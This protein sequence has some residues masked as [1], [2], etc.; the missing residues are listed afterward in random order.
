[1]TEADSQASG[2][3]LE[4]AV[5]A[6]VEAVEV[7]S[8][9]LGRAAPGGTSVEPAFELVDD[10]L[11]VRLE[12]VVLAHSTPYYERARRFLIEDVRR[13]RDDDFERL[14]AAEAQGL[15]GFLA[16]RTGDRALAEMVAAG[17]EILEE[18]QR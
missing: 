17:V 13:M 4:L 8:E 5:E 7:V 14:Y 1:M 15:F 18:E 6:D 3:W 9:I 16:Y 10:G 11:Q 12:V 2:A